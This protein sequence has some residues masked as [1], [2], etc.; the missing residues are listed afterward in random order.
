MIN[1]W[2]TTKSVASCRQ[3]HS[4]ISIGVRSQEVVTGLDIQ[5][6]VWPNGFA[7]VLRTIAI[8]VMIGHATD[9]VV[10]GAK[11]IHHNRD[12]GLVPIPGQRIPSAKRCKVSSWACVGMRNRLA[13]I[14]LA[15]TTIT[16][17]PPLHRL[18]KCPGGVH[19][20]KHYRRTNTWC[21]GQIGNCMAVHE[22]PLK[23]RGKK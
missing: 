8:C 19:G 7:N 3:V 15:H 6:T 18:R 12:E 22:L 10:V 2:N 11:R 4:P 5:R 16:K 21:K 9:Q 1:R 20:I 14:G 17:V 23:M 13:G